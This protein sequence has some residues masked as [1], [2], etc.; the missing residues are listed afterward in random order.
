[1]ALT[2]IPRSLSERLGPDGSDALVEVINRAVGDNKKDILE[3]VEERFARRLVESESRVKTDITAL[4]ESVRVELI[5]R[6]HAL[7]LSVERRFGRI[8]KMMHVYFGI[9]IIAMIAF[10]PRVLTAIQSIFGV[11][12]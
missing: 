4:I 6:I 10:Q 7:E 1:M 5:D 9:I 8:E 3:A 12:K 2:T 11:V